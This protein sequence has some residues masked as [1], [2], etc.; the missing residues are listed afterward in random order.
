MG[1]LH[2]LVLSCPSNN[3]LKRTLGNVREMTDE[4]DHF[5]KDA[6]RSEG[7]T[8]CQNVS[9]SP[10][11]PLSSSVQ[12]VSDASGRTTLGAAAVELSRDLALNCA[13]ASVERGIPWHVSAPSSNVEEP[14]TQFMFPDLVVYS[15][16]PESLSR[17]SSGASDSSLAAISKLLDALLDI[18]RGDPHVLHVSVVR[19]PMGGTTGVF[20]VVQSLYVAAAINAAKC[21][22]LT[23]ADKS[24]YVVGYAKQPF[25]EYG[26]NGF[27]CKLVY[28]PQRLA[29]E[30]C[31]QNLQGGFCPRRGACPQR[32][33]AAPDIVWLTVRFQEA[34]HHYEPPS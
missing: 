30:Y 21:A 16:P 33:L 31:C 18:L 13:D 6:Q 5:P 8:A 17:P 12:R 1:T 23:A 20:A 34:E 9:G 15:A 4:R 2:V 29:T 19:G 25:C 27:K 22:L 3:G 24:V 28:V 10:V 14:V 26:S 11:T 32:H 7:S